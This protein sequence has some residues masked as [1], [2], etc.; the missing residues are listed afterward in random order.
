[1]TTVVV[2]ESDAAADVPRPISR[3]P[4]GS[5]ATFRYGLTGTGALVL[6]ITGAIGL[7]LAYRVIPTVRHFGWSFLT[8]TSFD[9][10]QN[11]AGIASAIVGTVLV[12]VIALIIA[13]PFAVLTALYITEYAPR[14]I[15][16]LLVSVVDLMAA[17]PSIV[18]GAW[19]FFLLMPQLLWVSRWMAT[20]L[21]WIPIFDIPGVD[22]RSPAFP[23]YRFELSAFTAGVVV[24]MMAIPLICSVLR[25]VFDQAPVGEREAAIGLG[26]TRWGVIR[27]VVLPFGRGGLIGGTMLGLGRALGETIAVLLVTSQDFHIRFHI[28]DHGVITISALIANRFSDARGVQLDSLLA[29]GFVLF[30]MTLVVN[31]AAAIIVARSR[32]GAGVDL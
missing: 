4:T 1:M 9:A 23:Q 17:V 21:G 7:F 10:T 30:L 28:L 2:P 13:V 24:A 8:S 31:T 18:Y 25:N 12:A 32:S 11:Q 22:P 3:R 26:A 15:R 19:G 27:T 6:V 29:A 16:S 14:R 20:Y 5:D